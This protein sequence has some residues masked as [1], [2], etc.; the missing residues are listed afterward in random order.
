MYD[1]ITPNAHWVCCMLMARTSRQARRLRPRLRALSPL[2]WPCT[3]FFYALE[4][5]Y[6]YQHTLACLG[7]NKRLAEP[8]LPSDLPRCL[9]ESCSNGF[10]SKGATTAKGRD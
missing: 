9:A 5:L 3:A 2:A 1:N 4:Q 7:W 6:I 8:T 10:E